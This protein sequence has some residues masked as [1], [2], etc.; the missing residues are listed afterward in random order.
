MDGLTSWNGQEGGDLD[1]FTMTRWDPARQTI[2]SRDRACRE[3]SE[4]L[5]TGR[6]TRARLL[7]NYSV[8]YL[9]KKNKCFRTRRGLHR[10][11]GRAKSETPPWSSF[12]TLYLYLLNISF[13]T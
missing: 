3:T 5:L 1:T 12:Y 8:N 13:T 10:S 7:K 11:G 6:Y 2:T 4:T 9:R